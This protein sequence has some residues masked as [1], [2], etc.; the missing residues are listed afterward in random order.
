MFL[1]GRPFLEPLNYQMAC[2]LCVCIIAM[3]NEENWPKFSHVYVLDA[4]LCKRMWLFHLN[5]THTISPL[6]SI[7]TYLLTIQRKFLSNYTISYTS[8]NLKVGPHGLNICWFQTS[9]AKNKNFHL[10]CWAFG[11]RKLQAYMKICGK[12][13]RLCSGCIC[14][15]LYNIIKQPLQFYAHFCVNFRWPYKRSLLC[16]QMYK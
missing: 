13:P 6:Y 5:Y 10:K 15:Q 16:V 9:C 12:A 8:R 2:W 14:A 3:F 11:C 1:Y 7:Y 4:V